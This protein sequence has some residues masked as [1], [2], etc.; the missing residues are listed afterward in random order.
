MRDLCV[1]DLDGTLV[2]YDSFG[3]TRAAQSRSASAAGLARALRARPA[4]M[5]RAGFARMA[6]RRLI[7]SLEGG[8]SASYRGRGRGGYNS[9]PPQT[10]SRDWRAKGAYFWR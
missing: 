2:P 8:A 1:F 10:L 4:C 5:S 7:S 9:S 6:H 3:R